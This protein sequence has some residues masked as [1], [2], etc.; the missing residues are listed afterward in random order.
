M[1]LK[2]FVKNTAVGIE[3]KNPRL[4]IGLYRIGNGLR[5]GLIG[6][7]RSYG[8]LF[9]EC[10]KVAVF[11]Y[12]IVAAAGNVTVGKCEVPLFKVPTNENVALESCLRNGFT[13]DVSVEVAN[14]YTVLGRTN[15]LTTVG[16]EVHCEV[17]A[18]RIGSRF[19]GNYGS[20]FPESY[21]SAVLGKCIVAGLIVTCCEGEVISLEVPACDNEAFKS[22]GRIT[23]HNINISIT[24][25]EVI[26]SLEAFIHNTAVRIKSHSPALVS[27][28]NVFIIGSRI[29]INGRSYG[30]FF[31]ESY[32]VAV[33][34]YCIVTA[35]GNVTV[36]KCEV[37]LLKVPAY[38]NVTLKSSLRN[39]VAKDILVEV[40]H[41]DAVLGRTNHLTAVGIE[42][43]CPI[44]N[45]GFRIG[46]RIGIGCGV[47]YGSFFP[48]CYECDVL[49]NC[50]V[51]RF[52]HVE[53]VVVLLVVPTN[54]VVA[55]ES[56]LRHFANYINIE[57]A[58]VDL[59]GGGT[60]HLTAIGVECYCPCACS[61]VHERH[62]GNDH[63]NY[64]NDSQ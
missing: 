17:L 34:C 3:C 4:I 63:H 22:S 31:P 15:H 27:G 52:R 24:G 51:C 7:G 29:G 62:R 10:Y 9:P 14:V 8:S 16:I 13:K 37:I 39:S 43:H 64:E 47:N 55:F 35:A 11:C 40:T 50:K 1:I 58:C 20:F 48:H 60:N 25:I 5:F 59:I 18:G 32:E 53:N 2:A 61:R 6:N 49:G 54:K 57:I 12:C 21:E 42:V 33:F 56:S 38:E 41:V 36:G 45:N 44:L 26:L 23:G 30:S 28:L 46:C 19:V